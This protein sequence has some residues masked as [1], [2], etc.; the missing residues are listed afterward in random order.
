MEGQLRAAIGSGTCEPQDA[1]VIMLKILGKGY[2]TQIEICV[3]AVGSGYLAGAFVFFAVDV[4]KV[5]VR[6]ATRPA[7]RIYVGLR[8]RL[9]SAILSAISFPQQIPQH[10]VG[11]FG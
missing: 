9:Y 4:S 10:Q 6:E 11:K 2:G 7:D 5:H 8:A 3:V 1:V